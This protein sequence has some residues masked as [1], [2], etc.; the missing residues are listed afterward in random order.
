[1]LKKLYQFYKRPLFSA[2]NTNRETSVLS[3]DIVCFSVM[4]Y[5]FSLLLKLRAT[6]FLTSFCV[7]LYVNNVCMVIVLQDTI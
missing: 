7:A 3:D 5:I 4:L 6:P 2:L 1:M